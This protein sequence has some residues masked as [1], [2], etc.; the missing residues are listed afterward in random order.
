MFRPTR[1]VL[2][3]ISCILVFACHIKG[4]PKIFYI[5][6]LGWRGKKLEVQNIK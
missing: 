2:H 1:D 4:L 3:L 5:D 6:Y